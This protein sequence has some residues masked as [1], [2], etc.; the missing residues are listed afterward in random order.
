MATGWQGVEVPFDVEIQKL[1]ALVDAVDTVVGTLETAVS[2]ASPIIEAAARLQERVDLV[3]TG[4]QAALAALRAILSDLQSNSAAHI[5]AVPPTWPFG[6]PPS[7]PRSNIATLSDI[8]SVIH[9]VLP[10]EDLLGDGGNYGFYRRV[11]ESIYDLGDLDRP[12]F[13]PNDYI[14]GCVLLVGAGAGASFL[15]AIRALGALL[16]GAS[17]PSLEAGLAPLDVPQ[18]LRVRAVAPPSPNREIVPL[19]DIAVRRPPDFGVSSP[20]PTFV[21]PGTLGGVTDPVPYAA[22]VTW[23]R[24][25]LFTLQP[26]YSSM[27]CHK[28][29]WHVFVKEG[30]KILPGEDLDQYRA[31][32]M[33]I[34]GP[35]PFGLPIRNLPRIQLAAAPTGCVIQGLDPDKRYFISAAYE[36][37]VIDWGDKSRTRLTMSTQDLST[38]KYVKLREQPPP[39][40]TLHSTPPD[41]RAVASPLAMFPEVRQGI[42]E[43]EALLD[44][45]EANFVDT[46]NEVNEAL[47]FFKRL[48]AQ[49]RDLLADIVAALSRLGSAAEIFGQAGAYAALFGGLGGNLHFQKE[50][51]RLLLRTDTPGRPTFDRGDELLVGIVF[52][53]GAET[54][55]ALIAFNRVMQFLLGPVLE[56]NSVASL[57]TELL[58]NNISQPELPELQSALESAMKNLHELGFD[59]C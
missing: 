17:L 52:L 21:I 5:L 13:G 41:W 6:Q 9:M 10:P 23:D 22:L 14:A 31:F 58:G 51:G 18:G 8:S 15:G 25:H 57:P 12:M 24:P 48:I 36:Y 27:V 4:V 2:L 53:A 16:G 19:R 50:M 26:S 44:L 20:F 54:P 55:E 59:D 32:T 30:S 47:D 38:Q 45:I 37:D 11:V 3:A 7:A 1:S 42:A 56:A 28:I 46:V 40:D 29:A 33:E 34:P 39:G 35:N 43:V 49:L